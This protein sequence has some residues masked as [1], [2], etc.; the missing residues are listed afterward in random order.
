MVSSA[1]FNFGAATTHQKHDGCSIRLTSGAANRIAF[2]FRAL[3][4]LLMVSVQAL[5]LVRAVSPVPAPAP[6]Q[7]SARASAQPTG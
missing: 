2:V 3:P 1:C 6:V 4:A 5:A 7:A